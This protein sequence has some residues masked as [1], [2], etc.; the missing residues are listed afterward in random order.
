MKLL[1]SSAIIT[2]TVVAAALFGTAVA[3]AEP[4]SDVINYTT[5]WVGTNTVNTRIDS[6]Y[7]R[8]T[9]AAVELVDNAGTVREVV[10]TYF[11]WDNVRYPIAAAISEDGQ[12]LQMT[13]KDLPTTVSE[14]LQRDR[15]AAWDHLRT[16]AVK[17]W[18]NGGMMAVA[19]GAT[20]GQ[21]VGCIAILLNPIAG[22][23]L[24]TIIGAG[25]GAIVGIVR[26]GENL[27]PA[28]FDYF[29]TYAP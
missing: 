1:R 14:V 22:C 16:E 20:V 2:S 21:V 28:I 15:G 8:E 6:G 23:I 5:T 27:Q 26:G 29:S 10:P 24:G 13:P 19:V 12:N 25:I 3:Q 4:A 18:E 9:D 11:T 17:W 7:F